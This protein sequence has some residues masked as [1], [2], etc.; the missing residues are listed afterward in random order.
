MILSF[1]IINFLANIMIQ[2]NSEFSSEMDNLTELLI[3][4]TTLKDSLL[5]VVMNLA[6][7]S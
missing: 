4:V 7:F 1:I 2:F 5:L 3:A 6:T